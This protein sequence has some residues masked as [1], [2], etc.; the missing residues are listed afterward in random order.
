M[1]NF[2][3]MLVEGRYD[4]LTRRIVNDIFNFIKESKGNKTPMTLYLPEDVNG[5]QFYQHESGVEFVLVLELQRIDRLSYGG[6]KMDYYINSRIDEEDDLL[7][8]IYID[9]DKE[10]EVYEELI[11]KLNEDVRHEIEHYI[12][13]LFSDRPKITKST[14][15]MDDTYQHHKEPTEIPAL[16]HGFYRRATQ[17]RKPLDVVM[18]EDLSKD[19]ESGNLTQEEAKDLLRIWINY[20]RRRLPKAIYS[21]K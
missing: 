12:Q 9:T 3:N 21:T 2:Y 19:I 7:I 13:E 5:K 8:D 6:E 4:T 17:E 18:W 1:I 14:A 10:P 11:Y 15:K 20:S 16:V